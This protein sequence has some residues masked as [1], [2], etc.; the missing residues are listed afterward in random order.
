M[1]LSKGNRQLLVCTEL[2]QRHFRSQD[3]SHSSCVSKYLDERIL[4]LPSGYLAL[5]RLKKK[6]LISKD[7]FK[8]ETLREQHHV[9]KQNAEEIN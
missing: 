1:Y 4:H 5:C 8:L 3:L 6:N 7:Y 2:N 9:L